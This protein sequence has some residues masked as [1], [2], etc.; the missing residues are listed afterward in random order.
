MSNT[1]PRKLTVVRTTIQPLSLEPGESVHVGVDVPKASYS[2]ALYS[3]GRGLITTWV[4]PARPELLIERLLPLRD[5]VAQVVYEAGPTGF[6]LVRRL[7]AAE[8]KA[9]VIAPSKTPTLPG[10]ETRSDRLDCRKLATFAQKGLL[11]PVRV[12]SEQEEAGG[13]PRDVSHL[14]TVGAETDPGEG[15]G[16]GSGADGEPPF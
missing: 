12:P 6:A 5:G 13:G 15:S 7:R 11:T 4:Q 2:V 3:D 1:K 10:P 8:L 14:V 16:S 9:E